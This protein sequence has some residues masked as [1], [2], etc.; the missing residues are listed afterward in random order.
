MRARVEVFAAIRTDARVEGL[1]VR[2]LAVRHGVHRRTV[3][4]A[5]KS[6]EPPERKTPVRP[7][8]RLAKFKLV[9]DAMLVEDTT[10]PRKQRHTARRVLARLIEEHGAGDLSYSTVRDY[11]RV[12]RAE[13]DVEAGRRL[14]CSSRRN[15]HRARR[16]KWTSVRSGS[17]WTG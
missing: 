8:A 15:T 3:R 4:A 16:P 13:I 14:R 9:I 7:S 6:A 10:A 5:L 1:S 17:C 11:V 2:A 12:R